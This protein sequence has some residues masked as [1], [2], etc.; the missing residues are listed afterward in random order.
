M[1]IDV[2]RRAANVCWMVSVCVRA[3][4][5]HEFK[6]SVVHLVRALV[7][8]FVRSFLPRYK[9]SEICLIGKTDG[10]NMSDKDI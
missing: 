2:V 9:R 6:Y 4:D 1:I 3:R 7:H 10:M 5:N 8:S